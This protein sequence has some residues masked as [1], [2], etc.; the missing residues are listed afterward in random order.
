MYLALGKAQKYD[1][2]KLYIVKL[3]FDEYVIVEVS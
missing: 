2:T 1:K 3:N